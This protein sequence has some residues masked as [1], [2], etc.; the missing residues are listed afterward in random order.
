MK[1]KLG[2]LDGRHNRA[3]GEAKIAIVSEPYSKLYAGRI[4]RF[5][6]GRCECGKEV[7]VIYSPNSQKYPMSCGCVKLVF[8][9]KEKASKMR[10]SYR[11]MKD[12]CYDEK[13]DAYRWYGAK[14][15]KVC[16]R[17]LEGFKFFYEDMEASWFLGGQIDRF[18]DTKGDYK[19]ENTRWAT[20]TEQQRNK[21]NVL[22]LEDVQFIRSSNL[23][24]RELAEMFDV[25]GSTI[26][27]IK[28]FKRW[29][30]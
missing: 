4:R 13:H 18:P 7:E 16:D 6:K 19:P 5:V 11:S 24:Q 26:S 2:L 22:K 10:S 1:S 8:K 14:G 15:V 3:L 27:R 9:D 21:S 30:Q 28:N 17:W 29:Q 20:P 12:R 25:Q 23:L